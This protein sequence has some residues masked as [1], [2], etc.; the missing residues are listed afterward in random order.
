MNTAQLSN[1]LTTYVVNIVMKWHCQNNKHSQI[2]D[3]ISRG[4]AII[5][6]IVFSSPKPGVAQSKAT[7]TLE[8]DTTQHNSQDRLQI[9]SRNQ[10]HY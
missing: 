2:S 8:P 6:N 7:A 4:H 3:R 1:R 5:L 10:K 9:R